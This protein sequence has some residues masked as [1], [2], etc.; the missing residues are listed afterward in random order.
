MSTAAANRAERRQHLKLVA[1]AKGRRDRTKASTSPLLSAIS[2]NKAESAEDMAFIVHMKMQSAERR[3]TP[4]VAW[5]NDAIFLIAKRKLSG[6]PVGCMSV[7]IMP[8]NRKAL[9]QDFLVVDGR[10]GKIA[11]FAML[12]RLRALNATKIAFVAL[13]NAA[14]L[15][16]LE[17]F[18]MRITGF[19]L[20]AD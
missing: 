19:M 6:E 12:E 10:Q 15:D 4:D 5:P 3:G 8:P 14:M 7:T 18:G 9:V 13:D 2:V 16:T 17:R 1:T 20:E 11:A